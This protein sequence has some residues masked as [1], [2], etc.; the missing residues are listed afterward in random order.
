MPVDPQQ[1]ALMAYLKAKDAVYYGKV[2]ELRDAVRGWLN[3]IPQTFRHYTGHTLE[4]SDEIVLQVSKLLFKDDDPER[5]II[6]LS[7]AEAYILTAAAYLHDAGM[8][9]SDKEKAEILSSDAWKSWVTDGPA[10]K[11]WQ[12]VQAVRESNEPADD[13]VRNFLAD[14]QTRFLIAEFVR[15]THH[16]RAAGVVTQHEAALGRFAFDDPILLRT[17]SDVCVAHGLRPHE[18]DDRD[19]YPDRRDVRGQPTNVR[20]MAI[21]LRLGDLL[22]M[23]YN[24]ACPLLLNAACPLPADSLAHWTQYRR[25]THRLTAPD[26]VEITAECQTQDEHRLLQDWC[27]WLVDEVREAR[28]LM[29]HVQRHSAWEPPVATLGSPDATMVIQPAGGATYT[30]SSWTIEM[31]PDAVFQRL[32]HDVYDEPGAF[33]RELIQNALDANR[34]QMYAD[35]VR[36]GVEPPEYPTRVEEDRRRRYPVHV[37]LRTEDMPNQLSGETEERQILT[38]E[39][40]GIGMDNEIIQRYFLQ[41]G[42]SYY[43]TDEFRRSFRFVPTSRFGLG[44]LSVFAVSDHVTVE[45]HKPS[46][47]SQDGPIRLTLTGPRNY[48]LTDIGRRQSSGTRI[49]VL[50]REPIE[51]EAL[52]KWVLYWCRRVEFP[53]FVED[54][55]TERTVEAER[56]EQFTYEMPDITEEGAK[57]VV[58]AFPVNL[59]GIEGEFYVFAGI[60]SKGESWAARNW[61]EYV[62]P[63][64][65]PKAVRPELPNNSRCLYG[66]AMSE[67]SSNA[68][69]PFSV[70]LDYRGDTNRFTLS[71]KSSFLHAFTEPEPGMEPELAVLWEDI[72]REHLAATRRATAEDA[73]MYKQMLVESF[74]FPSFWASLP[75]TIRVYKDGQAR[76]MSLEEVQKM[77][78]VSTTTSSRTFALLHSL[79]GRANDTVPAWDTGA[80]T[81]TDSNLE[82]LSDGHRASIFRNRAAMNIRWLSSGHLAID[83]QASTESDA[84]F[85]GSS[86]RP[87]GIATLPDSTVIGT[88]IHKTTDGIYSHCLLNA[89][90]PFVQWLMLVKDA[91]QHGRHGL[92]QEQFARIVS[93]LGDP[94]GFHGLRLASLARYVDGWRKLP[95]LPPELYPPDIELKEG[96][97]TLSPPQ[98]ADS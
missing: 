13:T 51:P 79:S 25:I 92:S 85:T 18:L 72:L 39:D 95:G 71:R 57:F 37:A 21:L 45:T 17:I 11:R 61:A 50:L 41:V 27:K 66:I 96:M 58:R 15:R 32:I 20:F 12:A 2:L 26:R 75:A 19:R 87:I 53:I 31:D 73:W 22:D 33:I 42:R 74:P 9:A 35:L 63:R 70:R 23:S 43:T 69:R 81:L 28:T 78:L 62:Y 29:A 4:H 65:H 64:S 76:L 80:A 77:P 7:S 47:P 6:S 1:T 68:P 16:L 55:G 40:C 36:D 5:P 30:P 94:L 48:L 98:R 24:R 38:V 52:T 46:S 54:L 97:F 3:Y 44:F 86:G 10:A 67:W 84:L 49:E 91:C 89:N 93:L 82:R 34:C 59:P 8:V 88:S 60:N 90:H 83:W 14:V 56:P